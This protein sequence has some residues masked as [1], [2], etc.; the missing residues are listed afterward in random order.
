MIS[1]YGNYLPMEKSLSLEDM[2][3]LHNEM[4]LE[5]GSDSDALELY[6]ELVETATRYASFRAQWC[7]LS[8]EEKQDKYPSRSACHNSLIVKFNQLARFLKMQGKTAEWRD[9]LRYEEDE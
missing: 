4:V 1:T 9:T 5:I 8:R 3:K 6:D 2:V 7:L